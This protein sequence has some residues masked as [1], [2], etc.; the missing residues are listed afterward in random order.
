MNQ[1][2]TRKVHDLHDIL[3]TDDIA[4]LF[5]LIQRRS[6]DWR[7][8]AA[9]QL[10]ESQTNGGSAVKNFWRTGQNKPTTTSEKLPRAWHGR[11]GVK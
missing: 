7:E 10:G 6:R 5:Q 9:F 3:A 11:Y 2:R 1:S 8:K 4:R